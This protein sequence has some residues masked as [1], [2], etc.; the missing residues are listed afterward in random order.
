MLEN[1]LE[2]SRTET[3]VSNNEL[4]IVAANATAT[5]FNP[6]GRMSNMAVNDPQMNKTLNDFP[7]VKNIQLE[8]DSSIGLEKTAEKTASV[9]PD[10]TM[11]V[12]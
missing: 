2:Q 11:I 6:N 7:T 4:A 3:E 9:K 8:P 1:I 10:A 5:N 12:K